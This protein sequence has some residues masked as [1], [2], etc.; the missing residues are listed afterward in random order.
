MSTIGKKIQQRR[1]DLGLTQEE[2]ATRMGYK[3]K[4][5]I[6]KIELGKNDIPQSKIVRFA[7]ALN[8]SP[9]Y[10][11]GW[12]ED[13][14]ESRQTRFEHSLGAFSLASSIL[15]E[16]RPVT[17]K[18][19]PVL[20]NVAC[21]EPIFANEEHET[22]I[23][24]DADV[25]ADF[26]LTAKGDSMINARIF[27]GDILFVKSQDTVDDGEIAVVLIDNEATVK[28]V[29]YDKENNIITLVPENPTYKPLRYTGEQLNQIRILG[30]VISGQ[31]TVE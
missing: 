12:E 24:A 26:C 5:T 25:R 7:E 19:L 30:K 17:K 31:Y 23:E 11:M 6:N 22:Y 18:R 21:G 16:L 1:K 2:L 10:L 28:R 3:S 20:G 14:N 4:S 29:Y 8:T 9:S 27:D 15:A 13:P